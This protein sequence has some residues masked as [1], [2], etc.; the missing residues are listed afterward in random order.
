MV[1]LVTPWLRLLFGLPSERTALPLLPSHRQVT[2][3]GGGLD[4][5]RE[6]RLQNP[7]REKA[8]PNCVSSTENMISQ[9]TVM[10]SFV[11]SLCISVSSYGPGN[12]FW[13]F[14][15]SVAVKMERVVRLILVYQCMFNNFD[16]KT[17]QRQ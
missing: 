3:G 12:I 4:G 13:K 5:L 7:L 17:Q 16:K 10:D 15:T 11:V 1:G 14:P 8:R 2:G 6:A 9:E